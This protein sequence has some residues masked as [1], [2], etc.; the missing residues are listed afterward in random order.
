MLCYSEKFLLTL[1]VCD[2]SLIFPFKAIQ[3]YYHIGL[4][5]FTYCIL[6]KTL[7]KGLKLLL[8]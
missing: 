3:L 7:E 6:S 2:I 4:P 5:L 8:K 1:N